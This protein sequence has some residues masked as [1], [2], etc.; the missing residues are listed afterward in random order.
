MS[1]YC[2]CHDRIMARADLSESLDDD[3]THVIFSLSVDSSHEITALSG[4]RQLERTTG[5]RFPTDHFFY[6]AG[7]MASIVE[8][9]SDLRAD[10]LNA[11]IIASLDRLEGTG[12]KPDDLGSDGVRVTALFTFEPGP[13]T[14]SAEMVQRLARVHATI[15]IDATT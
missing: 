9:D 15:W 6:S 1:S 10:K 11:A 4:L 12:V 3:D 7:A 13:E 5:R 2:G 14:I 8:N